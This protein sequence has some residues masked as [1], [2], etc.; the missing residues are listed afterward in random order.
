MLGK[1][2]LRPKLMIPSSSSAFPAPPSAE[3]A[4][5]PH[6][7]PPLKPRKR[8]VVAVLEV[9]E[10]AFQG[11]VHA[12]D[13]RLQA[14]PVGAPR[15]GSNAGLELLQTLLPGP[16]ISPLPV[17]AQ[18]VQAAALRGVHPPPL[19]RVQL[20]SDRGR[21]GL[22]FLQRLSGFRFVATQ[23]NQVV[24]LPHHL[25]AFPRQEM[26]EKVGVDLE[27]GLKNPRPDGAG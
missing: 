18:K 8:R 27:R 9:G 16:S 7:H 26:I 21:P 5:Q 6:A 20:P 15:L 1:E 14:L 17:I 12:E 3:D 2:S 10:P 22:H 11:S 23:D 24:R 4:A 13:D 25:V 19:D